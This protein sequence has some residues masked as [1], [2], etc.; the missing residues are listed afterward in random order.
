MVLIVDVPA[1]PHLVQ[2]LA[3]MEVDEE[4][5]EEGVSE[6]CEQRFRDR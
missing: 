1:A 2:S 3:G 6:G 5:S 4:L